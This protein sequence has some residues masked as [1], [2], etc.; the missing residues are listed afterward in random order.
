MMVDVR[1]DA[2]WNSSRLAGSIA[3]MVQCLATEQIE[4]RNKVSEVTQQVITATA[5]T[6][7]SLKDAE[8]LERE[9]QQECALQTA[10]DLDLSSTLSVEELKEEVSQLSQKQ[11]SQ[12][13]TS[14]LVIKCPPPQQNPATI[15][16]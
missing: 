4:L 12:A 2:D 1:K 3:P 13:D 8:V 10:C 6:E 11:S 15:P 14:K 16:K 7:C 5:E 9:L